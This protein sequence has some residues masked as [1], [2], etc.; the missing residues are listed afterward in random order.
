V[1]PTH[2]TLSTSD[3]RQSRLHPKLPR[4]TERLHQTKQSRHPRRLLH[5][6][7]LLEAG[8]AAEAEVGVVHAAI[9]LIDGLPTEDS[10]VAS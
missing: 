8:H 4:Q 5:L 1:L 2:P 9:N 3:R 7:A 6:K 10:L